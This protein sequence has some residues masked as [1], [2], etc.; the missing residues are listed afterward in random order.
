MFLKRSSIWT[1]AFTGLST[2][3]LL[4]ACSGKTTSAAP[5][6]LADLPSAYAHAVC[7]SIKGCCDD[8][9][10]KY[11]D[12][13]CVT[14]AQ[15]E[16]QDELSAFA[17]TYDANAA[18]DCVAAVRENAAS[19]TARKSSDDSCGRV[20][21]G[22]KQLGEACNTHISDCALSSA[23]TVSCESWFNATSAGGTQCVLYRTAQTGDPCSSTSTT[24]NPPPS[25]QGDCFLSTSPFFCDPASSTCQPR[26]AQG[27]ACD[28]ALECASGLLCVNKLC[29]PPPTLNQP[30]D[31]GFECADGLYCAYANKICLAQKKPGSTCSYSEGTSCLNGNCANGVCSAGDVATPE[32][33]AGIVQSSNGTS[34]GGSSGG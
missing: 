17:G 32:T 25:T 26:R 8:A 14:A 21:S 11:D 15:K 3:A 28:S 29:S 4:G 18:G 34:S 6:A 10:F 7:D 5:V 33:C 31:D 2:L 16:I 13:S 27:T 19:C 9:N 23:G 12:A 30:C 24:G 1:F 20:F 22:T